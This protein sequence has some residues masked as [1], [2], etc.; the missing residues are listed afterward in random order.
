M[1]TDIY[2]MRQA[3]ELAEGMQPTM[4][5]ILDLLS[6]GDANRDRPELHN[7]ASEIQAQI[8]ALLEEYDR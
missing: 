3:R 5:R 6:A 1:F 2:K 8:E 4:Q 7:R